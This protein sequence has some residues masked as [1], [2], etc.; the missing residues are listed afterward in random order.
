MAQTSFDGNQIYHSDIGN[1]SNEDQYN[2]QYQISQ[3]KVKFLQFLSDWDV[4]ST[5]SYRQ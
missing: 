2:A 5:N 3:S 4:G 1:I